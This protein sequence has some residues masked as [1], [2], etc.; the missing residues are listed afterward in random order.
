MRA[1]LL[2]RIIAVLAFGGLFVSAVLSLGHLFN[3]VVPCG[4]SGGCAAV[5]DHP[6]SKLFGVLPN[7]YMGFVVYLIL[8][9][10]AA[11]RLFKSGGT[12]P[13]WTISAG[14][15]L[16]GI[17]T[18]YSGW[19]TYISFTQIRAQC[20]WCLA[21]AV[22]ITLL[23][24]AHAVLFQGAETANEPP[25]AGATTLNLGLVASLGLMV[26]V[27]TGVVA[28][29]MGQ[30]AIQL[31]V[32]KVE[33]Q[34]TQFPPI[35]E[36]AYFFG[37]PEA[38][39]TVIEFADLLCPGCRSSFPSVKDFVSQSNGGI[40]F[41]FRHFPL[42]QL[43]GHEMALPAANVAE[44]AGRQGK[45]FEFI[46]AFYAADPEEVR[47]RE[48]VIEVG[49]QIGLSEAAI[50]SAMNGDDDDA[51]N[52][53]LADINAAHAYGILV[54]PTFFIIAEGLPMRIV[55]SEQLMSVLREEPYQKLIQSAR[56]GA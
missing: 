53:V 55:T 42:R 16:S 51:F 52:R 10:F 5:A 50:V 2:N 33:E 43:P 44:V 45:F 39:I 26:M 46:Q 56:P 47:Q 6:S 37:N 48:G 30:P 54:T 11:V 38:K 32:K 4:V 18:L 31:D 28:S 27:G 22:L 3:R 49:K 17:G 25:A 8:I 34:M 13:R 23:F 9:A 41:V 29:R 24:F 1:L 12:H 21:S 15:A 19:L 14:Y 35:P 36:N 40:R 20:N 7:A